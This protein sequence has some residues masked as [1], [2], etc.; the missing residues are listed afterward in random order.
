MSHSQGGTK[1]AGVRSC[2][3]GKISL[4]KRTRGTDS[5]RRLHCEEFHDLF[6]S[7]NNIGFL[8]LKRVRRE[9]HFTYMKQRRIISKVLVENLKTG[10]HLEDLGVNASLSL[11]ENS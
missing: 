5:W 3:A 8:K 7:S 9:G 11:R 4:P 2:D 6:S 1:A 10:K